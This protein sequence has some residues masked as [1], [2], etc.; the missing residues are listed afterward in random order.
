MERKIKEMREGANISRDR[1]EEKGH[2]NEGNGEAE[3][4]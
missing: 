2:E 1:R 4:R 3:K